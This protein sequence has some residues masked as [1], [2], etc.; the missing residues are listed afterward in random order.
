VP[1]DR[2]EGRAKHAL[3]DGHG[4][5]CHVPSTQVADSPFTH[6]IWPAIVSHNEHCGRKRRHRVRTIRTGARVRRIKGLKLAVKN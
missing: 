2:I 3:L 6:A 4:T 5:V 1:F